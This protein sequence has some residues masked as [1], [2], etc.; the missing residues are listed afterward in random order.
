VVTEVRAV[1]GE[2][3]LYQGNS[4]VGIEEYNIGEV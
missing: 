3:G 1:R 4:R 2:K